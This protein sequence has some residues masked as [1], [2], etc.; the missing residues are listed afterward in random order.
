MNHQDTVNWNH[1]DIP[2][3]WRYYESSLI[4]N[5]HSWVLENAAV[6]LKGTKNHEFSVEIL[7]GLSHYTFNTNAE[8]FYDIFSTCK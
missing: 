8:T 6:F 2:E 7:Y 1:Y 3:G 5:S 4:T